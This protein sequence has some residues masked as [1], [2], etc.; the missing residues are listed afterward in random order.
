MGA[1]EQ[2]PLYLR[3]HERMQNGYFTTL[4]DLVSLLVVDERRRLSLAKALWSHYRCVE[5]TL[6]GKRLETQEEIIIW[7]QVYFRL[8]DKLDCVEQVLEE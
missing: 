6:V 1:K 7:N 4:E 3:I 8:L 2:P 5:G